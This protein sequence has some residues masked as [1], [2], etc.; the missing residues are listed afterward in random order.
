[1]GW[2]LDGQV[3]TVA[4]TEGHVYTFLASLP[5]MVR[6]AAYHVCVTR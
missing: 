6:E 5:T 2:A 1:M 3:L 4:T